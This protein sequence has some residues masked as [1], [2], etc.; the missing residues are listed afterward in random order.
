MSFRPKTDR[1]E[2]LVSCITN[3]VSE[4]QLMEEIQ[5]TSDD[6]KANRVSISSIRSSRGLNLPNRTSSRMRQSR[7][8]FTQERTP[9]KAIPEPTEDISALFEESRKSK[10]HQK[11]LFLSQQKI[12]PRFS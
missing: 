12:F 8:N 1:D 9:E 11:K 3:R 7:Q 10:E 6:I 4:L 5:L 2:K